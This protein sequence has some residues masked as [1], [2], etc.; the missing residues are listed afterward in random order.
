MATPKSIPSIVNTSA[1]AVLASEGKRLYITAILK[2]AAID[3]NG[4]SVG[5]VGPVALP[6]PITCTGFDP[7][8][9]GDI[10]YYEQ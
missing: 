1:D 10:A 7:N 4:A 2:S 5:T 8:A 9:A 3:I 6:S